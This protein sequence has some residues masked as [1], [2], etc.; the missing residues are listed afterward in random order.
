MYVLSIFLPRSTAAE[1]SASKLQDPKRPW[2][3]GRLLDEKNQEII[4]EPFATAKS[5]GFPAGWTAKHFKASTTGGGGHYIWSP[6]RLKFAS[7]NGANYFIGLKKGDP[8]LTDEMC[9]AIYHKF[10]PGWKAIKEVTSLKKANISWI[11]IN[12]E[13]KWFP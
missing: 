3:G 11:C 12:P 5:E 7:K 4:D 2:C 6:C 8:S 10:L 13:G 1:Y 9:N